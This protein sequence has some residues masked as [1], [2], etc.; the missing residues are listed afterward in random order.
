MKNLGKV[1][2]SLG[3][4]GVLGLGGVSYIEAVNKTSIVE[5]TKYES[6]KITKV[7]TV[8]EKMTIKAWKSA[9]LGVRQTSKNTIT[10]LDSKGKKTSDLNTFFAPDGY[11]YTEGAAKG[12]YTVKVVE[13]E[14]TCKLV[15]TI[16]VKV[17]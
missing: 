2:V 4:A 12:T 13:K 1:V 11:L 15:K 10:V 17:K 7:I 5:N 9:C 14:G 3:L 8:S 6:K 16:T